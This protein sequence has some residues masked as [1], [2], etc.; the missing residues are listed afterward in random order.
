MGRVDWFLW[1]LWP[2]SV[3]AV[4][5]Q[6]I[7]ERISLSREILVG[8]GSWSGC[9]WISDSWWKRIPFCRRA[10]LRT[11]VRGPF[12]PIPR[13]C[14]ATG[15]QLKKQLCMCGSSFTLVFQGV[16]QKLP[17]ISLDIWLCSWWGHDGWEWGDGRHTA[18]LPLVRCRMMLRTR[19][20]KMWWLAGNEALAA[21][22]I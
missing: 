6:G 17:P 13:G 22:Q 10:L 4:V 14:A 9:S 18:L 15:C 11:D 5:H 16:Q 2:E 20:P 8:E 7:V 12:F 1:T 3:V 21:A 19:R